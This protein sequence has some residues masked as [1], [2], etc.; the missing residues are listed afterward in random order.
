MVV[1]AGEGRASFPCSPVQELG[2]LSKPTLTPPIKHSGLKARD[3]PGD[4][5]GAGCWALCPTAATRA[6]GPSVCPESFS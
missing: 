3:E 1:E 5:Q 6:Q 4:L 2:I